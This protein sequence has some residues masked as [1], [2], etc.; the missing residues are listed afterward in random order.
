MGHWTRTWAAGAA[1]GTLLLAVGGPADAAIFER[2]LF[3]PNDHALTYDNTTNFEWLDLTKTLGLS[4]NQA[5]ESFYVTNLGF[6]MA[7]PD[8]VLGL[9]AS[10]GVT[11]GSSP[12]RGP[13]VVQLVNLLGCTEQCVQGAPAAQGWMDMGDPLMTAYSF[14]QYSFDITKPGAPVTNGT[15]RMNTVPFAARDKPLFGT[16]S[17]LVRTAIPEPAVWLMMIAGFGLAG[18]A[19]RRQRAAT[20]GVAA[21]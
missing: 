11:P 17:F 4:Y 5:V 20:H 6:R 2:D 1:V 9:W 10:A 18:A 12:G 13:A 19:I 16:A 3:S 14:V 8:E 15:A 21:H 7:T